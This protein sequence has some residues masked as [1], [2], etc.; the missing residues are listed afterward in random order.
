LLIVRSNH[1]VVIQSTTPA[2]RAMTAMPAMTA[3]HPTEA[4]LLPAAPN[5]ARS[6]ARFGFSLATDGAVTFAIHDLSGRRVRT[7]VEGRRAAGQSTA[8]WD[9]RDDAGREVPVGLYFALLLRD[10]RSSGVQRVVVTR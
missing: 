5:P 3:I 7:L 10:G 9:L 4:A 6:A 8:T 2:V 1:E